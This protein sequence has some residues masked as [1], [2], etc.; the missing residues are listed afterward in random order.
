MH[1]VINLYYFYWLYKNNCVHRKENGVVRF[2]SDPNHI[3][4]ISNAKQ[5]T[6]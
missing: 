6:K 4:L 2:E 3:I 1:Y 5:V